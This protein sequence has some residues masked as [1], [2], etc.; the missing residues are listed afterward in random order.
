VAS[1]ALSEVIRQ[2]PLVAIDYVFVAPHVRSAAEAW[3]REQ[4]ARV[5][6]P[7]TETA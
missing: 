5:I 6:T 2:V 7:K 4:R 3:L 1:L